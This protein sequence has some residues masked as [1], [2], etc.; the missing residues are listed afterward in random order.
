MHQSGDHGCFA[1]RPQKG[2]S[3]SACN[4][5]TCCKCMMASSLL[6]ALFKNKLFGHLSKCCTSF[7]E[8]EGEGRTALPGW[9]HESGVRSTADAC[10][11]CAAG[12]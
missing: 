8:G 11:V 2:D 7:P 3:F 12:E 9:K 6:T 1:L 5:R 4:R 10:A